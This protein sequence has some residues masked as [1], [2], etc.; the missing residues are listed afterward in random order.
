M[1]FCAIIAK[2][3]QIKV[4]HECYTSASVPSVHI[5]GNTILI[6]FMI[7]FKRILPY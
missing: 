7:D 4:H 5:I 6:M 1:L 2:Y 3:F